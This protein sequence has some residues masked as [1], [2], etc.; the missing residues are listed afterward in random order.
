MGFKA[1]GPAALA[2]VLT[3]PL[4]ARADD[5]PERQ[6]LG[7]AWWT[8]PLLANTAATLPQGHFAGETYVFDGATTGRYDLNGRW[9]GMAHSDDY[10]TQT[11]LTYGVTDRFTAAVIPRFSYDRVGRGQSSAEVGFGDVTLM[12]EYKLHQFHE[13][14]WVPTSSIAVA[15]TVPTGRY[16]RLDRPADGFG[17]GAYTTQVSWYNQ[18][19]FWTPRGRILRARLDFTWST[20]ARAP[21]EGVSVF[22]TPADF[23]GDGK[24]GD[25]LLSIVAFEYNV[26]RHWVWAVDFADNR[27]AGTRVDGVA[28]GAAY[29]ANSGWGD[30]RFAAPAVEYNWNANVGLIVGA[31]MPIG[32]RNAGAG[33]TPVAALN[34]AF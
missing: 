22:G 20:S 30:V 12:G 17:G 29:Y 6:P 15:E 4:A 26:S 11:F 25:S 2:A 32:G 31:R 14:S 3:F 10:G 1:I 7:D 24:P 16:D 34:Y 23:R 28:G 9:R 33:V 18:T 19:Y 21:V 13:G 5:A 8:G 27:F